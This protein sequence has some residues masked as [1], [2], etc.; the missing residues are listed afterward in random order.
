MYLP[1]SQTLKADENVKSQQ[2]IEFDNWINNLDNKD[3]ISGAFLIARKGKI[4]Y[5]KTVGKVHPHRNDMITLDSSFNLGSISKHFTAMG[6]MLLKQQNK[7]K[8]DDKVQMHIPEFPY[9]NITIR[10]L[11]NH[12]SG[13]IDYEDLTDEFWNKRDFTN[14]NMIT[15]FNTHKP[16]LDFP[17]GST[18]E[19]SNTGYV[20][21]AYIIEKLSN[22]SLEDFSKLHIFKPLGMHNTRIFTILSKDNSFPSRVYGQ[23]NNGM[24]DLYYLE[25]V[26]GDGAVYSTANDL[27]KWHNGLKSN[28]LLPK[29]ELDKAFQPAL[30]TNGKVSYYGFGWFLHPQSPNII[31]HAGN[32]VGFN[33]DYVR[34]I[35]DDSVLIMLTNKGG[36]ENFW[37]LRER[38][39]SAY[40]K[41]MVIDYL[42][43]FD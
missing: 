9:K 43:F 26:T 15:L 37:T 42:A 20:V 41:N 5:S 11:L 6:I 8:Y 19:Y 21:L 32:W 30:L 16:K 13:M 31:G 28:I 25:G 35:A 38:F 1:I 40:D 7:L 29:K 27:L 17:A 2:L 24:D 33:N 3:V 23:S 22:Q 14:K 4:I 18:A 39:I 12:T 36:G 10:H 34:N